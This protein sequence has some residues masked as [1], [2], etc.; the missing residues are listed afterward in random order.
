MVKKKHQPPSKIRYDNTHPIISIR[1][2]QETKRKLD[3]LRNMSG[4][5]LGD[6]LREALKIQTASTNN[7]FIKGE[8]AGK[9][10]YGVSFKCSGCGGTIWIDNP[11][12]K[13]AATQIMERYGWGHV[14]CVGMPTKIEFWGAP[15]DMK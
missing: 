5:S 9:A 10:K 2:D 4:K 15:P 7:A 8:N 6:I 12:L 3:D 13:K 14:E 1:V 11:E